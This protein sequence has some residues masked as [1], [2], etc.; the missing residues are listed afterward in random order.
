MGAG[1]V[2]F[3]GA[4]VNIGTDLNGVPEWHIRRTIAGLDWLRTR[5]LGSGVS[6]VLSDDHRACADSS[7]GQ[8][9]RRGRRQTRGGG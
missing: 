4:G 5:R 9:Q 8:L 2:S 1:L 3:L 6:D 7:I